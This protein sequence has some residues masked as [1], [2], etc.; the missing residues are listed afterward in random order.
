MKKV[1]SIVA[2]A[3]ITCS[4]TACG[5]RNTSFRNSGINQGGANIGLNQ[6]SNPGV[7]TT[8]RDGVYIGEGNKTTTG[9]QAAVVTITGGRISNVVLKTLD[10]KGKEINTNN[11]ISTGNAGTAIGSNMGGTTNGTPGETTQGTNDSMNG[12]TVGGAKGGATSGAIDGT[13]GGR[14]NGTASGN[15]VT[16]GTTGGATDG[17]TINGTTAGGNTVNNYERVRRDLA[18]AI[19]QNQ[20]TNVTI[21]DVGNE[22]NAVDNWKLAVNRALHR[23]KK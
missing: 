3:L 15:M 18:S 9:S 12:G 1:A 21:G 13:G 22:K 2:A 20:T 23:A 5:N 10:A 19:V 16:G 17:T 4:L 6:G 11:R 14:A 7:T 8:Y